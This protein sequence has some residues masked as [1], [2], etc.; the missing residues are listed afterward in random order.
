MIV[1]CRLELLFES[2]V[3]RFQVA[4][5]EVKVA[6]VPADG[7]TACTARGAGTVTVTM[8]LCTLLTPMAVAS[9]V[10]SKLVPLVAASGALTVTVA[11]APGAV[12]V[13]LLLHATTRPMSRKGTTQSR[14]RRDRDGRDGPMEPPPGAFDAPESYVGASAMPESESRRKRRGSAPR[15]AVEGRA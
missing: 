6:V 10:T 1:R 2:R 8:P 15:L 5:P 4:E 3:P 11:I 9:T 13:S 12:V 14:E 7:L